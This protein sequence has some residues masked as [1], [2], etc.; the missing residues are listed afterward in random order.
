MLLFDAQRRPLGC[1][2]LLC[3]VRVRCA[4][5]RLAC[6]ALMHMVPNA[7]GTV[8]TLILLLFPVGN[9][10][11]SLV[12]TVDTW[13]KHTMSLKSIVLSHEMQPNPRSSHDLKHTG[14]FYHSSSSVIC[15]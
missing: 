15:Q 10:I 9:D 6:L 13:T 2:I 1:S 4:V 11:Q 14:D 3:P 5:G 12:G 8:C 7:P